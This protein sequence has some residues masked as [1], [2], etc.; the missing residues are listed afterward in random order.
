MRRAVWYA[1]LPV[2]V[3]AIMLAVA[4][5]RQQPG[6]A[7]GGA[8]AVGLG[9]TA[10]G[11][12]V[13]CDPGPAPEACSIARGGQF[14]L[15]ANIDTIPPDGF[16]SYTLAV[17]HPQLVSKEVRY[18]SKGVPATFPVSGIG[19]EG[20]L[21]G[22]TTSLTPP[23]P[24]TNYTGGLVEAQLDCPGVETST[25]VSILVPPTGVRDV[26]N[27]PLSITTVDRA[28]SKVAATLI[29]HCEAAPVTIGDV[30]CDGAV[31]SIDAALILQFGAN[32][33]T[34][35]ECADSADVNTDGAT[36]SIDAALILQWDAGLLVSLP[37]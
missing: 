18:V 13:S 23:A 37:P 20:F 10:T 27:V 30:S 24:A 2:V 34:S 22:A 1:V 36:N 29:V 12:G 9:L 17:D 35:L 26:E 31:N 25:T 11:E 5:P 33:L 32:L 21:A 14:T 16:R 6:H 28:G 3:A 4:T 19:T 7:A 8:G 15:V